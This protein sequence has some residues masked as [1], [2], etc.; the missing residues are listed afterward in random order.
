[1]FEELGQTVDNEGGLMWD[2]NAGP[3]GGWVYLTSRVST[4]NHKFSPGMTDA[5]AA[6]VVE[7]AQVSVAAWLN[8]MPTP[9]RNWMNAR[10]ATQ[11]GHHFQGTLAD[12]RLAELLRP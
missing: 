7:G 9:V 8:A 12:Y 6:L 5:E 2:V 4:P 1:M 10:S 11:R 3:G